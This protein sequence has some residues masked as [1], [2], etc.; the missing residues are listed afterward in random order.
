MNVRVAAETSIVALG[1]ILTSVARAD[2]A[3]L[4]I[5]GLSVTPHVMAATMRYS[6]NPEPAVG[7]RVQLFLRNDGTHG[8]ASI[9]LDR[10]SRVVFEGVT[11]TELLQARAWSWHDMPAATPGERTVVPPGGLT[12][13][14][15]NSRTAKYG[16]GGR[17]R[18]EAGPAGRP[19]LST[20]LA[21]D[22]PTCWLSAVTFLGADAAIQPDTMVVHVANASESVAEIRSCRLW[23]PGDARSPRVLFAQPPLKSLQPFN[24]HGSIPAGDCGGFTVS[25]GP[26]PL[27]YA[28]VETELARPGG[29][30]FSLWA[31]LRIKVERFDISGGWVNGD[32]NAVTSETF[33]KALKRLSVNTAHLQLT[34]G[35][36]DTPLYE[37][38][39]LKY[40]GAANPVAQY[41][42]DAM[43]P[44]IHAVEFLGEPQYGG[45]RPVAPQEVWERLHPFAGTRLATSVTHSDERIW[46]DYAGL[47][48]Y[49]HFDAYRV[50]AP[51]PDAWRRYDRWGGARITWG[52]PLETIGDMCRSLR[53]LN[54][55][56]PC[57]IWSQGPHDGWGRYGGRARTSPTP[58]EIRMQ[59]YHAIASRITSLYWFNLSLEALTMW[60]DTLD[61][62][63]RIGRELRMMDRFLLEGDACRFERLARNGKLD[64]DLASVCGPRAALLFALDLDYVPDPREK[65]F[66]FGAPRSATW[67]FRLP[68]YLEGVND[69]FRLDA[70]GLYDAAWSLGEGIV[71][72]RGKANRVAVFVATP[73]PRLRTAIEERRQKLIAAEAAL[74]FDPARN[75]AD[76]RQLV[77]LQESRE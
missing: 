15:F 59:A 30:T 62:L 65:V 31:F 60:R 33:L 63:G 13:W 18:F 69:V 55:P 4:G 39:P 8:D 66:R 71:E 40:F 26:L 16:P 64:W 32:G 43:L 48:D 23:L 76:F 70:D 2:E 73:D 77:R 20:E 5:A 56:L 22:R 41:D 24:G 38:Y 35:Y 29:E 51:S 61:E 7:A 6:R 74:R 47:S 17:V 52:A 12:V 68:R 3:R 72:I 10:D 21:L 45:G 14:T 42:T 11:P 67:R 1:M 46:R 36:S 27:T 75:D 9:V 28:A 57:A 49:P 34:P 19:W 44:K 58:D 54:R 25:T 50:T 37:R 53:E